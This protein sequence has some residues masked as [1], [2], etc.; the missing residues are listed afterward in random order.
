MAR[1]AIDVARLSFQRAGIAL[2]LAINKLIKLPNTR[3]ADDPTQQATRRSGRP[4][5]L[6]IRRASAASGARRPPMHPRPGQ[7]QYSP[8]FSVVK[9]YRRQCHA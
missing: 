5:L 4:P 7:R 8:A 9:Y 6:I 3:H 2:L 1:D